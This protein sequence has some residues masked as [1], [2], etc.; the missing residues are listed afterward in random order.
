MTPILYPRFF[1]LL[2][3]SINWMESSWK[4]INTRSVLKSN[5]GCQRFFVSRKEKF[6]APMCLWSLWFCGE[7]PKTNISNS[8]KSKTVLEKKQLLRCNT[9][10]EQPILDIILHFKFG[11][12][13]LQKKF[14]IWTKKYSKINNLATIFSIKIINYCN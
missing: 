4:W 3:E 5:S 7:Q 6:F 1:Q 12:T 13:N 14:F 8:V 2:N 9:H 10:M 11:R